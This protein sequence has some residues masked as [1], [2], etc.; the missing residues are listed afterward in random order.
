MGDYSDDSY[1]SEYSNEPFEDEDNANNNRSR[2]PSLAPTTDDDLPSFGDDRY[3]TPYQSSRLS[4]RDSTPRQNNNQTSYNKSDS[5]I[6]HHGVRSRPNSR[7]PAVVSSELPPLSRNTNNNNTNN[8]NNNNNHNSNNYNDYNNN[9]NDNNDNDDD[10]EYSEYSD[11]PAESSENEQSMN[12]SLSLPSLTLQQH[13]NK[14]HASRSQPNLASTSTSPTSHPII[15]SPIEQRKKMRRY[16]EFVDNENNKP[17]VQR[18]AAQVHREPSLFSEH[19]RPTIPSAILSVSGHVPTWKTIE[20]SEHHHNESHGH[21]RRRR[22]RRQKRQQKNRQSSRQPANSYT[23]NYDASVSL[24]DISNSPVRNKNSNHFSMLA[25]ADRKWAF[26]TEHYSTNSG[27]HDYP[28]VNATNTKALSRWLFERLIAIGKVYKLRRKDLFSSLDRDSDGIIS[29]LDMYESLQVLGVVDILP[30]EA[31]RLIRHIKRMSGKKQL[32]FDALEFAM[33]RNNVTREKSLNNRIGRYIGNQNVL[34][35]KIHA[36]Q[37][38]TAHLVATAGTELDAT[39]AI[40]DRQGKLFWKESFSNHTPS[41]T[42]KRFVRELKKY[43]QRHNPVDPDDQ[44]VFRRIQS[45]ASSSPGKVS[46]T[47]FGQLLKIFGPMDKL[48]QNVMVGPLMSKQTRKKRRHKK[49]SNISI[50]RGKTKI[51]QV[52]L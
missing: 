36:S 43:C 3:A 34:S 22:Q 49:L 12:N 51:R 39:K 2:T 50:T 17:W 45:F 20:S 14:L 13:N 7:Q 26:E 1:E 10:D 35:N 11:D 4:S 31:I 42:M 48:I 8:N 41:V 19:G 37:K 23:N 47:S 21:R 5:P 6:H 28:T 24:P 46:A 40:Q 15:T 44:W 38:M 33:R 25:T 29:P 27:I 16:G 52:G 30:K 9:N 18:R 32:N